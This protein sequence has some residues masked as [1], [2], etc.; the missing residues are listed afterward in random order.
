MLRLLIIIFGG[1]LIS[2]C[3]KSGDTEV[4]GE[5]V[6]VESTNPEP[7]AY[8]EYL[9]CKQGAN[10]SEDTSAAFVADWNKEIDAMSDNLDGAA[11]YVPRGWTDER[12][13]GLWVL[14]WADKAASDRGWAEYA[15]SGAQERLEEKYPDR[16]NCGNTPGTDRFG[17]ELYAPMETPDGFASDASYFLRNQF[18]NFKEGK[19]VEDLR[20]FVRDQFVPAIEAGKADGLY[21][22]F[23]FMIGVPD[24]EGDDVRDFNWIEFTETAEETEKNESTFRASEEGQGIVENFYDVVE[25]TDF[26][27]WDGRILRRPASL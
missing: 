5:S 22:S 23:W 9:W 14:R 13:D 4:A 7:A 17:F 15:A 24:Y 10:W 20:A 16:L 25:C 1:F 19:S 8:Y 6:T 18:C 26:Q 2:A 27:G 3:N 21:P 12:Y 11:G